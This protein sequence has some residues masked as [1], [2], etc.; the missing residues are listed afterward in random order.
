MYV[1]V[2]KNLANGLLITDTDFVLYH[3]TQMSP[4]WALIV[5]IYTGFFLIFGIEEQILPTINFFLYSYLFFFFVY[6][7]EMTNLKRNQIYL[8][9]LFVV[10]IITRFQKQ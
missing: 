5:Y 4:N 2:A 3:G 9:S 6:I 8:I 10:V 7:L 1:Y